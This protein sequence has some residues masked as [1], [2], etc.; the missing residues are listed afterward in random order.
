MAVDD[1][2]LLVEVGI[3]E[4]TVDAEAGVV[5]QR[6]IDEALGGHGLVDRPGFIGLGKVGRHDQRFDFVS[7]F[8]LVVD[9]FQ[10]VLAPGDRQAIKPVGGETLRQFVSDTSRGPC[11]EGR[12]GGGL[13]NRHAR[14]CREPR[15]K[16][17]HRRSPAGLS[18]LMFKTVS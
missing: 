1:V 11:E 9:P 2:E 13:P 8:E 6:V 18:N 15:R 16:R 12:V 5:Y 14:R 3:D 17:S 7:S 4:R 10:A